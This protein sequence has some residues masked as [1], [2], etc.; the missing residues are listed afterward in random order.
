MIEIEKR[1]RGGIVFYL[2]IFIFFLLV[3]TLNRVG[4]F[5]EG[6]PLNNLLNSW[7]LFGAATISISMI[8]FDASSGKPK[9]RRK[10]WR[11]LR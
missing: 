11:K 3:S 8:V 1:S 5:G 7:W 6:L 4:F 10:E 2:L 9:K